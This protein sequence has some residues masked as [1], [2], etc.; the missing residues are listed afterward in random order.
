[1]NFHILATD[2]DGTIATHGKVGESTIA[3][4][5]KLRESGR[6]LILV[7]GRQ[8][9]EWLEIFPRPEL[10]EWVVAENGAVLYCPATRD[11]R[12]LCEPVPPEFPAM[13]RDRGIDRLQVGHGIVA[14][15][16]PNEHIVL[17]VL[18]ELGLDRQIIFNKDAVMVLPTG[19]NKASGLTAALEEL[20]LSHHNTVAVG[21]AENDLPMLEQ[22]E[23]GAAVSNA[24]DSVK[25]KAKIVLNADHGAGV[26]ELI[27]AL[28]KDDLEG[29]LPRESR[30]G[31]LLGTTCGETQCDVFLPALGESV[32]VAGPSGSGKS[33]AISG[34]LERMA[35]S[36]YQMCIIDPE[37]DYE[38]FPAAI[39][40]GT[41]HYAPAANDVLLPLERMHT[42]VVNLL[43]V[44]LDRRPEA[45]SEVLR[46]LLDLRAATGRPHW[47]I[48][49]EAHHLFPCDI[50]VEGT[51]LQSPPETSLMITVHPGH[52]RREALEGVT[53]V[54][55]VGSEP[56]AT[57]RAFC[58]GAGIAPPELQPVELQH[59]QV[60]LWRRG[61]PQNPVVVATI[62]GK[63]E[64]K[65]HIRKYSEGDLGLGSFTFTGP[66][67]KLKLVA[68][69]M[70]TFLRIAEGVD[71]E[72]WQFH[73]REHHL[74]EWCRW[75]VKNRELAEEVRDVEDKGGSVE[76]TRG[77]IL[78]AIRVRYTLPS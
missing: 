22:C 60:L 57:V 49:D 52:I 65:R 71:D 38:H 25:A 55:A 16:L 33:S 3:A 1:M 54:M 8:L 14:A 19:V 36:A 45:A 26:E 21:D 11:M 67:G 23:C 61:D 30:R 47:F 28:L 68:Q 10:F 5:E 7:S 2:Y 69:N 66:E 43:G 75:I 73:L 31:L 78:E 77:A 34:L 4:L 15:W 56:H 20:K 48:L 74:S 58:E 62:P 27:A 63:A 40:Y 37:G 24:L 9:D 42:V 12:L 29:L 76:D 32:L 72:T 39:N 53:I 41:P 50:P 13:L 59:G 17:D 64:H 6:K 70:Q 44:E 35:K 46:K 51:Q 18:H